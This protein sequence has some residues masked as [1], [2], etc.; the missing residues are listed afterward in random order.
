LQKRS[1]CVLLLAI[2]SN[3]RPIRERFPPPWRLEQLL[4]GGYRV[5]DAHGTPLVYVYAVEGGARS[6]LPHSLTPSEAQAIATAIIR[7]PE[8]MPAP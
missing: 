6:A 5:T 8:L 1:C 4:P 2:M 3:S 7:L